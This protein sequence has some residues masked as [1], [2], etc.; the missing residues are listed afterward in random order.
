[1][2]KRS[3]EGDAREFFALSTSEVQDS[4][5]DAREFL[6][7][8]VPKQREAER[9]AK[10]ESS[11]VLLPPGERELRLYRRLLEIRENEYSLNLDRTLIENQLKL[12]I[13]TS[14]GLERI[15]TWKS[16]VVNRFDEAAFK[17]SQPKLFE[18]FMRASLQRKFRLH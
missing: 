6:A 17:L 4:V 15:A 18:G 8:F 3:S 9:L 7:E 16:H 10:E 13:G 5:R 14:D 1:R 11:G 12:V 2:S